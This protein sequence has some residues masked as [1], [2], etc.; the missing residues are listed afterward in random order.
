MVAGLFG[1][2]FYQSQRD[3]KRW[4]RIVAGKS[5]LVERD[6]IP[7]LTLGGIDY[8]SLDKGVLV[9]WGNSKS[10]AF[11]KLRDARTQI[12]KQ[13]LAGKSKAA[14]AR[15]FIWDGDTWNQRSNEQQGDIR[16]GS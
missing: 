12:Q 2:A 3:K 10:T 5:L 9:I 15:I 6:W 1:A 14:D 16:A 4:Q 7:P 11:S 13:Q 8:D